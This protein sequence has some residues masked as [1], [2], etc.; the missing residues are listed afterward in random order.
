MAVSIHEQ[1]GVLRI[2]VPL[3]RS[4]GMLLILVS[5][6]E[7]YCVIVL[8]DLLGHPVAQRGGIWVLL[9]PLAGPA[10]VVLLYMLA[11]HYLNRDEMVVDAHALRHYYALGPIPVSF[12]KPFPFDKIRHLEVLDD[13]VG[14]FRGSRITIF[15]A[16][17]QAGHGTI[18]FEC[19]GR[20]YRIGASLGL[21]EA[22]RVI[23]RITPYANG[24]AS[25]SPVPGPIS[26]EE[27]G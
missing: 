12:T 22:Q 13:P 9:D 23:D 15:G 4:P 20:R 2:S 14:P 5:A 27:R 25:G 17:G 8:T 21:L 18:A 11:A 24:R 1:G 7:F 16:T 3:P 19:D 6:I 10:I 26:P